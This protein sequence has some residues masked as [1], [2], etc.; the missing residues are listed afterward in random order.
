M[1]IVIVTC[2]SADHR[3]K[4]IIEQMKKEGHTLYVLTSD[5]NHTE[6]EKKKENN[7]D[8]IQINTIKYRKNISFNRIY[9]HYKFSK[10]VV[11][12]INEIKPDLIYTMIPPNFLAHYIMK[13]KKRNDVKVIF[14]IIDLW[15][16]TLPIDNKKKK[17]LNLPL[18]VWKSLRE[19][20]IVKADYIITECKLYNKYINKNVKKIKTM[21]L[22]DEYIGTKRYDSNDLKLELVYLGTINHIIDIE[23]IIKLL[24]KIQERKKVKINIIGDGEKKEELLNKLEQNNIEYKFYGKIFD[25]NKKNEIFSN[26]KYGIHIMKDSSCV[27]LTMKSIEYFKFG[28]PILNNIKED[29]KKIV[30]KYEVGFNISEKNIDNQISKII[31]ANEEELKK[32]VEN[33][34]KVEFEPK[35][36]KEKIKQIM[37]CI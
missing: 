35:V 32:N 12:K 5:F 18:K 2:F 1:K 33:M 6:K 7:K 15:P 8:Y 19:K 26:C 24:K 30:E 25:D 14:D 20:N 9:S 3:I 27:G 28:L 36:L 16:E 22:A 29:S 23:L 13:Y 34:Y 10:D 21:Y 4:Y 11:K 31:N 17:I 37:R